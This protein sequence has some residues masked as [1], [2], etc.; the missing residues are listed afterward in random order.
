MQ[1]I[2][3]IFLPF[4]MQGN[5]KGLAGRALGNQ[6]IGKLGHWETR[7]LGR[8]GIVQTGHWA[9]RGIGKPGH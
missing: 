4:Y 2:S 1:L 3:S 6:G 7:A 8:Q 9:D 5:Q